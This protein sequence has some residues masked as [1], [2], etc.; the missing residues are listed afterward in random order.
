[1]RFLIHD[2][3]GHPFQ[4]QLSRQLALQGHEAIHAYPEGLPG[5][6]GRLEKCTSD[7]DRLLI[8]PIPLSGRFRKYS[9]VRRLIAH[10]KYAS[11]LRKLISANTPD[12]VLSGNTPIDI[13]IEL[14]WYC[15]TRGIGFV[16]WVQDIYYRGDCDFPGVP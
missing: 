10:R 12:I 9:P 2:F 1:M 5:P 13:Q 14:L 8:L 6:K 15:R 11:D 7:S 3:A 16:H 4:V